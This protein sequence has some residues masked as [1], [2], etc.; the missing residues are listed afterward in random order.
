MLLGVWTGQAGGG[1]EK[2][3]GAGAGG[4]QEAQ[5]RGGPGASALL[6]E[7]Q[8]RGRGG[9]G[10]VQG[11]RQALCGE[12]CQQGGG[13]QAEALPL[14]LPGQG[15]AVPALLLGGLTPPQVA[16]AVS[17]PLQLLS[18]FCNFQVQMWIGHNC[19]RSIQ[20]EPEQWKEILHLSKTQEGSVHFFRVGLVTVP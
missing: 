1:Q 11:P 8:H 6:S 10:G 15:E 19:S 3:G 7:W 9:E 18:L 17:P 12:D 20:T 4:R 13:E 5:A 14:L 2:G 16:L